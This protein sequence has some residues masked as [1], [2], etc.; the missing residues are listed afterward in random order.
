MD[1]KVGG[2]LISQSNVTGYC[3]GNYY[4][5][6]IKGQYI[7]TIQW[8]WEEGVTKI[9]QTNLTRYCLGNYYYYQIKCQYLQNTI[10]SST[11][12]SPF[13]I[14]FPIYIFHFLCV[15]RF[16]SFSPSLIF[17]SILTASET[18]LPWGEKFYIPLFK[19]S[20]AT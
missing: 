19:R 18:K 14:Y 7:Y 16:L 13:S 20:F 5:Y 3:L 15:S 1:F 8:C 2:W 6:Q 10:I 17:L 9:P 4:Y 11:Q 12:L